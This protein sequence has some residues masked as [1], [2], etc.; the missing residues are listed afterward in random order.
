L[1]TVVVDRSLLRDQ[2]LDLMDGCSLDLSEVAD[3]LDLFSVPDGFPFIANDDGTLTGC[4]RV[5]QWLLDAQRENAYE[6]KSLREHHLYHL[7]RLLRFIRRSRAQYRAD[8]EGISIN[9]WLE[10]NGEP[11][12]DLTDATRADLK[13]YAAR[14]AEAIAQTSLQTEVSCIANFYRYATASGWIDADPIPRWNGRITLIPRG[15]RRNRVSKFLN[16]AQTSHFLRVGLRGDGAPQ[17]TGPAFPERDYC[18]GLL[19]ATTGLRREEA[20]LLLDHEVPAP[21]DMAADGVHAFERTGKGGVTRFV[22]I[23]TEAAQAINL[24]RHTERATKVRAA[25]P[26]LRR[27]RRDGKLLVTDGYA[28]HR[29]KPALIVD[30]K[31]RLL[32]NFNDEDR[33]RAVRIL[34]DGTIE[35]LALFLAQGGLPPTIKYWDELFSDARDR[36]HDSGH[37]DRPP[38][39]V[40]VGPHTMRH[41]FAVRMLAGLM[42]QGRDTTGDAYEFLANP[43]LTVKEL[44]GHA[45]VETT[46][47]YLYAAETWQEDI[48]NVLREVAVQTVG[49]TTENPGTIPDDTYDE[50]LD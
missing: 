35:P 5:N 7:G 8:A 42:H 27:K 46:H 28:T 36:V 12:V 47:R 49:H 4:E 20:G 1:R 3:A 14:R 32:T 16:P 50:A 39:H 29:G 9:D 37:A 45:S 10:E 13:A 34:D 40:T 6:L 33:A 15:V 19:L 23:T 11:K 31:K 26:L 2:S 25:Q 21:A 48:P 17:G 44:L 22:Y 41:T 30:G 43:V 24:Y 38:A 18:Y